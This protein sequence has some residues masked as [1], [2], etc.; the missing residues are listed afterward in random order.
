[1]LAELIIDNKKTLNFNLFK[2]VLISIISTIMSKF[3]IIRQKNKLILVEALSDKNFKFRSSLLESS[4]NLPEIM[5]LTNN[6]Q[7]ELLP[8]RINKRYIF[9][10]LCRYTS[11]LNNNEFFYNV[12]K[13]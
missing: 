10:V 12:F 3:N 8:Q 13:L 2:D 1:M 7:I 6:H 11:H 5:T 4:L 9:E